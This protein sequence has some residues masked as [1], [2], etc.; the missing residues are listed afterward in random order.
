MK[1][2]DCLLLKDYIDGKVSYLN[3]SKMYNIISCL[4]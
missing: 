4:R 1:H 2:D 3:L